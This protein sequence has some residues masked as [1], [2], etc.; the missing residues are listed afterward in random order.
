MR[1]FYYLNYEDV[2]KRLEELVRRDDT[3]VK[4]K[5]KEE[6]PLGF[7]DFNLPIKHYT[8]GTGKKHIIVTGGYH[9]AEIITMIFVVHLMED[10][11]LNDEEIDFGEYTIHF[12]PIMN[13]EGYVIT[14]GM[15]DLILDKCTS[16]EEKLAFARKYWAAYREDAINTIKAQKILNDEEKSAQ[17]RQE[18]ELV[19]RGKKKYQALFDEIDEKEYLKEYSELRESVLR[20]IRDN[21]YPIGVSAAWTANG[22]GVDLSGNVPFNQNI[23]RYK[24]NK[25]YAGT[26]Y[27]NIR[28]DKPGPI[29]TPCRD[30][31][32][33]SFERE[34][35]SLMNMLEEISHRAGEEVVA[36][37][38]YHSVMGKIYQRPGDNKGMM[39]YVK[40]SYKRKV[41]DNYLGAR[42]FR[43]ENAYD[44]IERED[45]YIYINEYFRLKYG[46]NI[47]VE[48][49]RMGSN[50]IGPLADS[51]TFYDVTLRPN[52]LAF[53]KFVK[54]IPLIKIMGDMWEEELRDLEDVTDVYRVIDEKLKRN[55]ELNVY[56]RESLDKEYS[57]HV[58]SYYEERLRNNSGLEVSYQ[59][60]EWHEL[61]NKIIFFVSERLGREIT[62]QEGQLLI[63][64]L[65]L[66]YPGIWGKLRLLFLDDEK[67]KEQIE[68]LYRKLECVVGNQIKMNNLVLKK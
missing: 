19:L 39:P 27:S 12:I 67:D 35:L 66:D 54:N 14:T 59:D 61:L 8:M 46:I 34:N 53:K 52:I 45:P 22:H 17:E 31:D 55:Q 50:P 41:I 44:I 57:A 25:V 13:P 60:K 40:G 11:A 65:E 26:A 21:D 36:F 18:A 15:H 6:Y 1:E 62:Y 58:V 63:A 37:L 28:C 9:A 32:K 64:N 56:L 30:L 42:F 23:E 24:K 43:E 10:L 33:F 51:E 38:N 7:T 68:E 2:N 5:V 48:L 3:N 4:V 47:Q 49:S 20:I 29:N 16:K